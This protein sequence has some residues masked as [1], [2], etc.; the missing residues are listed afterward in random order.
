VLKNGG[1][2]PRFIP[3]VSP[4]ENDPMPAA[5][6]GTGHARGLRLGG[7]R[8]IACGVWRLAGHGVECDGF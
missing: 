1:T 7:S 8:G 6:P 3:S 4:S 5:V 2:V